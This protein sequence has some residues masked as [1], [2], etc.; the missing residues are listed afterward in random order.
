MATGS[1]FSK[2]AILALVAA[3]IACWWQASQAEAPAKQAKKTTEKWVSTETLG[4]EDRYLTQIST[5]KP[6]YKPE[7]KVY[8]RGVILHRTT[9]SPLSAPVQAVI[10]IKGLVSQQG[11]ETQAVNQIGSADNLAALAG[12]EFETNQIA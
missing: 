7:E 9:H 2:I 1:R 4:G 3:C 8:I 5:D 10:D 11:V 6:I 12:K